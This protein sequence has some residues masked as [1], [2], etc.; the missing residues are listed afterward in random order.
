[1][2]GAIVDRVEEFDNLTPGKILNLKEKY[3]NL[4][5]GGDNYWQSK[6]AC[7]FGVLVWLKNVRTIKPVR[8]DKKDWRAWVV[9]TEHKNFGLSKAL[10]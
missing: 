6:A 7:K 2:R 5:L 3:N 10:V 4:I 9:L 8:I 1:M